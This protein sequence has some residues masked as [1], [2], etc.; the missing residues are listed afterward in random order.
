MSDMELAAGRAGN[1]GLT[2]LIHLSGENERTRYR[3][4][5]VSATRG[6]SMTR[7]WRKG[8][9]AFSSRPKTG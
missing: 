3:R 8:R 2:L 7:E 9:F 6:L 1:P 4:D 5:Q